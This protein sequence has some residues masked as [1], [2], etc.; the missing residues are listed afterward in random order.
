MERWVEEALMNKFWKRVLIAATLWRLFGPE[1]G[2][3][4]ASKQ[5]HPLRLPG[6]TVF[7]GDREFFLRETGPNE[8]QPLVLI[9]GLGNNSLDNWYELI[10]RLE[11][12]Y[13]IVAVDMRNHGKSDK[14]RERF[15]IGQI[16][17]EVAGMMDAIGL[18]RAAVVGFSMGG[19]IAQELA[20][21]H[22]YRVT[23][24]VL[25]GTTS[26]HGGTFK[27]VRWSG[28][29]LGRALDR[30]TGKGLSLFTY[31][32]MMLTGAVP[33]RYD[34]WYRE[35]TLDRDADLYYEA[36]FAVINFDSREWV[37]R[38]D[39]PALVIISV[40]DQ[41]VPATWQYDLAA[42]L[43][44]AEVIELADGGHEHPWTH[45]DRIAIA[46]DT[47]IGGPDLRVVEAS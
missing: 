14:P 47:F 16:A 13:R 45:A 25:M 11:H 30:L 31:R 35:N 22:P 20:H 4:Y 26:H 23:R 41:L 8:G 17:D 5:E 46:I 37:G 42:R 24:M 3:R 38:L 44:D 6:R 18:G 9:H 21:R 1:L 19:M 33:A 29:V 15:E 2:H 27:V 43:K 28:F 34:R 10:K 39:V 36:A 40:K 12:R 32:Y 7:V